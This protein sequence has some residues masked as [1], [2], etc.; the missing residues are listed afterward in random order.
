[1]NP[2]L[3]INSPLDKSIISNI[4][5]LFQRYEHCWCRFLFVWF[6]HP[7]SR[8]TNP[9]HMY[10]Y[11]YL[12]YVNTNLFYLYL[13]SIIILRQTIGWPHVGMQTYRKICNWE[14][15]RYVKD[16]INCVE[17]QNADMHKCERNWYITLLNIFSIWISRLCTISDFTP[18]SFTQCINGANG[19]R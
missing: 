16:Y 18:H 19:K 12:K 13:N 15:C 5:P 9:P 10:K 4:S 6:V 14:K 7:F 1:M 11:I 3:Q 8:T 17:E 2:H